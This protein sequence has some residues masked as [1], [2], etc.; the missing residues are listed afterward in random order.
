M[1]ADPVMSSVCTGKTPI[2]PEVALHCLLR[3]LA[4]GSHLDIRISAGISTSSFYVCIYKCIN[5]LLLCKQLSIHF[6]TSDEEIMESTQKFQKESTGGIIDGCV[7][8]LDGMLLPIQTLSSDKTG[9]DTAHYSGHYAEYGINIQ[10]ACDSVCQFVYVSVLSPGETSDVV[11]LW[12]TSF[13]QR[14]E[15]LPLGMYVLAKNAYFCLEHLLTPFSGDQLRR[16]RNDTYNYHLSQ[17]RIRIE[18][19][20]S[21]FVNKWQLFQSPLQVKLKNAGK[22]H[23][24]AARLYNFCTNERLSRLPV[25]ATLKEEEHAEICIPFDPLQ[26]VEGNSM[27]PEILVDKIYQSE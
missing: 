22:V 12:R 9:N 16:P 11:A 19:T 27:M 3:W 23:M 26:H 13:C 8:C 5:A 7:A 20:F 2:I 15:N 18:M 17:L 14:I 1:N 24:C 4:G 21:R 25:D 10:A 6:P